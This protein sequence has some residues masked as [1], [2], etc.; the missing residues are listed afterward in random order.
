M[1]SQNQQT[2]ETSISSKLVSEK[3]ELIYTLNT[4]GGIRECSK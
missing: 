3:I 1:L 4:C 2:N